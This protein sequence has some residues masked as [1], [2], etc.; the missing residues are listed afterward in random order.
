[1]GTIRCVYCLKE[2]DKLTDDHVIPKSWY[3]KTTPEG[4]EKFQ[5]PSCNVCNNHFSKIESK[6]LTVFGLCLS[7]ATE[8]TAEVSTSVLR[9]MKPG[10]A[11][12]EREKAHRLKK[13]D[14]VLK[15]MKAFANE[16][17]IPQ[18]STY[19]GF[20]IQ[21]D[22]EY[23]RYEA[24]LMEKA[25]LEEFISKVVKGLTYR[26]NHT[27]LEATHQIT[28]FPPDDNT[29][30][31]FDP[32]LERYGN[33]FDRG[34][35]LSIIRALAAEDPMSSIWKIVLWNKLITYATVDPVE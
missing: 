16:S 24:V 23:D 35:G 19:P 30:S 1:M 18:E 10:L 4:M 25:M 13:R 26:L 17:A 28:I 14:N 33:L 2:F 21:K 27:Y 32:I 22:V 7:P 6:L 5:V 29:K 3:P 9:S 34:P 8:E 12:T 15:H 31:V 11:D 20:G